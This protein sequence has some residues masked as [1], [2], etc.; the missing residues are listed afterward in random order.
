MCFVHS[1]LHNSTVIDGLII[2]ID[3]LYS[4]AFKKL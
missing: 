4:K 2:K 1:C 3:F